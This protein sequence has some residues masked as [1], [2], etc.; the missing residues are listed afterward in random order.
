MCNNWYLLLLLAIKVSIGAIRKRQ[1]IS[2][3]SSSSEANGKWDIWRSIYDLIGF[4]ATKETYWSQHHSLREGVANFPWVC[5]GRFSKMEGHGV[6]HWHWELGKVG[7]WGS[8]INWICSVMEI[9]HSVV[10]LGS[11]NGW[12]PSSGARSAC[13]VT[14]KGDTGW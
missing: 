12:I 14:S 4:S 8:C 11:V 13:T 6:A 2:L 3:S 1:D 7:I 5:H 9:W 10:L